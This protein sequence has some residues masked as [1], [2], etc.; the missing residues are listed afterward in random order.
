ML[1]HICLV[2]THVSPR[3]VRERDEPVCTHVLV[4]LLTGK[5]RRHGGSASYGA[6]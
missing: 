2:E 1:R 6:K 4:T 5:T 3:Q